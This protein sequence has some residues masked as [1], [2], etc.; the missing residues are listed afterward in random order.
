MIIYNTISDANNSYKRQG[1]PGSIINA[2][3][4][5][6]ATVQT[7]TE[8]NQLFLLSLGFTLKKRK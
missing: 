6:K 4:T 7:L 5:P 8:A 1:S 2:S 3:S